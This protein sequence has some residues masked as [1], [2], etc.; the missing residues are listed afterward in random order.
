MGNALARLNDS[1]N[2]IHNAAALVTCSKFVRAKETAEVLTSTANSQQSSPI[3]SLR[4]VDFG[5]G[6][7]RKDF[8]VAKSTMMSTIASWTM[9]DIDQRT[10][11]EGESGREGKLIPCI[12]AL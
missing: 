11:G 9:G 8:K 4:K 7:E 6:L 3:Q 2:S 12:V 5:S 1:S 10:H